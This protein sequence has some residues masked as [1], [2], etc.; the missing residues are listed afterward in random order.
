M[1]MYF[2]FQ[3]HSRAGAAWAP[4]V[5]VCESQKE[6][7]ITVEMPGV[8]KS[9]V[10]LS[11]MDSTLVISGQKR[12]EPLRRDGARYLCVERAYGNFRRDIDI[13]VLIDRKTARAELKNGLLKIRLPK[14]TSEGPEEIPIL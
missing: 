10:Q 2:E 9:D 11:W 12:E 14:V 13:H 6:I 7:V 4:T 8:E 1:T 3:P 5:D